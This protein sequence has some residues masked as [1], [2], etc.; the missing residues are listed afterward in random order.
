M[1]VLESPLVILSGTNSLPLFMFMLSMHTQL[2][3]T[4]SAAETIRILLSCTFALFLYL[5]FPILL[6]GGSV[7]KTGQAKEEKEEE[8]G[9]S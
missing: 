5:S 9:L 1:Y 6:L 2:L 7:S 8:E 4:S 3:R